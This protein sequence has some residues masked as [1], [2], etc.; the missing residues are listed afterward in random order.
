MITCGSWPYSNQFQTLAVLISEVDIQI[1]CILKGTQ[2][3]CSRGNKTCAHKVVS[4][5]WQPFVATCFEFC[6]LV[7]AFFIDL[8]WLF[9]SYFIFIFLPKFRSVWLLSEKVSASSCVLEWRYHNSIEMQC[10]LYI[11]LYIVYLIIF[12]IHFL[13]VIMSDLLFFN[14][15]KFHTHW[16]QN[17]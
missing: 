8:I 15:E 17:S 10:E 1:L 14:F 3:T 7:L 12:T 9:C 4:V 2:D 5:L 16:E 13:F 6:G 11:F